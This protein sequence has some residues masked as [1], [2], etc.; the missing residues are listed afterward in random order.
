MTRDKSRTEIFRKMKTGKDIWKT[1]LEVTSTK[2][3]LIIFVF[4]AKNPT[5]IIKKTGATMFAVNRT[6]SNKNI[7]Y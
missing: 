1:N 6:L 3:S 2:T 4:L 5:A 7:S